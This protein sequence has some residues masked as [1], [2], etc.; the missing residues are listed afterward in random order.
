M[1]TL[2]VEYFKENY[3]S[4]KEIP[5]DDVKKVLQKLREDWITTSTRLEDTTRETLLKQEYPIV[6]VDAV[7]PAEGKFGIVVSLSCCVGVGCFL[8]SPVILTCLS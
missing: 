1:A 8:C 4:L 6:F 3:A 7:K 2:T 5:D